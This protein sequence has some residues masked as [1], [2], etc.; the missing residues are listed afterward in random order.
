M[1]SPN[2]PVLP[3][4][5]CH[6]NI[7]EAGFHNSCTETISLREDNSAEILGGRLY[8]NHDESDHETTDHTCDVD[9]YCSS[10]LTLLPW[11]LYQIRS[12]DCQGVEEARRA[13]ADLLLG[14]SHNSDNGAA[15]AEAS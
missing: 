3:C 2:M 1:A 14:A 15:S 5:N 8:I 11:R 6:Q 9:A 4:P 12:M 13:V 7:L 10:C